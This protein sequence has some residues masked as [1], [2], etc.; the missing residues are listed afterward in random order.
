MAM[1]GTYGDYNGTTSSDKIYAKIDWSAAHNHDTNQITVQA[2]LYARKVNST[3]DTTG[4][5]SYF[6]ININGSSGTNGPSTRTIPKSGEWIVLCWVARTFDCDANGDFTVSISASGSIPGTT[7]TWT[8]VSGSTAADRNYDEPVAPN[9]LTASRASTTS[10]SLAWTNVSSTRRPANNV[11]IEYSANGGAWTEFVNDGAGSSYVHSGIS[12]NTSFKYRVHTSNDIGDSA[13]SNESGTTVVIPY[14]PTSVVATPTVVGGAVTK[15]DLT[16]GIP[17]NTSHPYTWVGYKIERWSKATNTWVLLQTVLGQSPTWSDTNVSA[18]SKYQYRVCSYNAAGDSSKTT[19][20]TVYTIPSAP[21]GPTDASKL[22]TAKLDDQITL[23]WV[24]PSNIE[25]GTEV[26]HSTNGGVSYTKVYT[27]GENATSYVHDNLNTT[28]QHKYYVKN[29]AGTM[30]SANLD[31]DEVTLISPP[32][33]PTLTGQFVNRSFF[34]ARD[35]I[36]SLGWTHN[37]NDGTPQTNYQLQYDDDVNFANPIVYDSTKTAGTVNVTNIAA[38]TLTNNKQYWWRVRTWGTATEGGDENTGESPWSAIGT[39]KTNAKPKV[40]IDQPTAAYGS[41]IPIIKHTYADDDDTGPSAQSAHRTVL[42]NSSRTIL[43]DVTEENANTETTL[44]Y[45]LVNGRDYI[46]QKYVKDSE[47]LWSTVAEVAF[48]VDEGTPPNVPDK[49]TGIT[50][51]KVSDTEMTIAWTAPASAA[52][53][54][55]LQEQEPVDNDNG[56]SRVRI[57]R[58]DSVSKA[59]TFLA[60]QSCR[61]GVDYV[62]G[63]PYSDTST[64]ANREYKYRIRAEATRTDASGFVI[65]VVSDYLVQTGTIVTTP[66]KP[67]GLMTRQVGDNVV[68]TWTGN[69]TYKGTQVEI[70]RAVDDPNPQWSTIATIDGDKTSYTDTTVL[71]GVTY[72]YGIRAKWVE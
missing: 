30:S 9:S 17:G 70:R 5:N 41:L 15:I 24:N 66:A 68:L 29:I 58:Y 16:I 47:E 18:D 25:T 6:T 64:V 56:W 22:A 36:V 63:S 32:S 50:V 57:E 53:L 42:L 67:T 11:D 46:I 37:P 59:W 54:V 7:F 31:S 49:P 26:Y 35:L 14:A 1:S 69:A 33:A 34:D 61:N 52:E 4:I 19:S 21:T 8:S 45:T 65:T 43:I 20:L 13:Y 10:N 12:P 71:P 3:S 39:F 48:T 28:L 23:T 38:G 51:T 72:Q 60:N 62:D 55:G 40:T 27:T 44:D 2:W